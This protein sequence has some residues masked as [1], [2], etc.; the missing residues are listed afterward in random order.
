MLLLLHYIHCGCLLRS[1]G[2]LL[3]IYYF[4]LVGT[5]IYAQVIFF[6][7]ADCKVIAPTLYYWLAINI[8]L[9]YIMIAYGISLW[10]AYICW[11]Q[12]EEEKLINA[13]LKV[14]MEK[15]IAN[16]EVDHMDKT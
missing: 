6:R 12:E 10:G 11:A 15:M 2:K 4:A 13:A 3:G 8:G 5:M 7:G 16:N 14:K 1:I 9:F